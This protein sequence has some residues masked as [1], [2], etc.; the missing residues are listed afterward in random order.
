MTTAETSPVT[1]PITQLYDI[2]HESDLQL[3]V[4]LA[5]SWPNLSE[6]GHVVF[7]IADAEGKE[8]YLRVTYCEEWEDD[9]GTVGLEKYVFAFRDMRFKDLVILELGSD[10][11]AE[12]SRYGNQ[13]N[14][15]GYEH[16]LTND[17]TLRRN[18]GAIL[19]L[20]ATAEPR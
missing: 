19:K 17:S 4:D 7:W 12:G 5:G 16:F 14:G 6:M 3:Q 2:A 20:I 10:G 13:H 15:N 8:E 9:S 18:A 1:N 11:S